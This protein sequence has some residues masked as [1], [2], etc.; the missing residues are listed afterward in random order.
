MWS[1]WGLSL[2]GKER[3]LLGTQ[4][5]E[6]TSWTNWFPELRSSSAVIAMNCISASISNQ[7]T[8]RRQ[9]WGCRGRVFLQYFSLH[10]D[11][12][13]SF[14]NTHLGHWVFL[15][16][17]LSCTAC[18]VNT[19]T[20]FLFFVC[21]QVVLSKTNVLSLSLFSIYLT[22]LEPSINMKLLLCGSVEEK[23]NFLTYGFD[24][25]EVNCYSTCRMFLCF[26][27][28]QFQTIHSIVLVICN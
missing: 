28:G 15:S 13:F 7:L 4:L 8:Y 6:M 24:L 16:F 26:S 10:N 3:T 2:P 20:S 22:L 21:V 18:Y 9:W 1:S 14:R 17:S 19:Y 27:Y 5:V 25:F 23:K 12:C 11:F